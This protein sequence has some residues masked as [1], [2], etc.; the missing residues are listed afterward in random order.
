MRALAAEIAFSETTFVTHASG[1][2]YAMRIFTPT[3]EMPFAGHPTLGTAYVL[4]SEGRIST[5]AIQTVSA[6]EFSVEVSLTDHFAAVRQLPPVFG[7][8][9]SD[10]RLISEAAGV[11]RR[12]LHQD[13]KPQVVGTG[14]PYLIVPLASESAVRLAVRNDGVI[15]HL[16][17]AAD[18]S[19][20]YLFAMGET[21][22]TVKARMFDHDP[23]I[24]E[25]AATGSA[26]GPLGAYLAAHDADGLPG[27]LAIS[28]GEELGRPS[29]LHVRVEDDGADD[30]YRVTVGGG[31][32]IVGEGV[33]EF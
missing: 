8:D 21:P 22:G 12:D 5:P 13:W 3:E 24:Q 30:G 20:L 29:T 31:V 14:L 23:G 11:S 26:A 4:A 16:L 18:A 9:A 2:R 28:Q 17:N 33:F 25:D 10:V 27:Q 1:S 19:G 15:G 7:P 6:G 32:H